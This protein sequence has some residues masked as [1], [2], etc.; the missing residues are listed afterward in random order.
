MGSEMCIRDRLRSVHPHRG[1]DV[2]P[3]REVAEDHEADPVASTRRVAQLP[4]EL[5]RLAAGSQRLL[6][7]GPGL[8]RSRREQEGRDH[9]RL[10]AAGRELPAVGRRSLPTQQALRERDRRGQAAG[11]RL[12]ADGR[13]DRALHARRR[14]LG[15]GVERGR[16]GARRRARLLRG[17]PD[18][19]DPRRDRA[20]PR[21]AAPSEGACR[22]CRR[23]DAVAAGGRIT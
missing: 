2:Q 7:P 4:V 6:T 21:A 13:C 16:R 22:Q 8:H 14:H 19:R 1:L 5:A 11:S 20:A 3:A 12:P 9:P 10:P 18:A 17:H 15:L 23:P